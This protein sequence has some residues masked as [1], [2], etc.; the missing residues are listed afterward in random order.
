MIEFEDFDS[1]GCHQLGVKTSPDFAAE[2]E[3][4][5]VCRQPSIRFIF[6][7]RCFEFSGKGKYLFLQYYLCTYITLINIRYTAYDTTYTV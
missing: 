1:K 5:T 7:N 2:V 4:L 6:T 3:T